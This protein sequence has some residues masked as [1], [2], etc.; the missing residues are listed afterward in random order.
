MTA[1]SLQSQALVR[2]THV[3]VSSRHL[4][5]SQRLL[6]PFVQK[7]S[8]QPQTVWHCLSNHHKTELDKKKTPQVREGTSSLE[9]RMRSFSP[10][11]QKCWWLQVVFL[12]V[13]VHGKWKSVLFWWMM[14]ETLW[15]CEDGIE[16]DETG[17]V[18]KGMWIR[19]VWC[20]R[21]LFLLAGA[22]TGGNSSFLQRKKN[23]C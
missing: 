18:K 3:H 7:V 21:T 10:D 13:T 22:D 2:C 4:L 23:W 15:I 16:V 20:R 14:G 17:G 11:S 8:P 19:L 9:G 12:A 1:L 6:P 5:M